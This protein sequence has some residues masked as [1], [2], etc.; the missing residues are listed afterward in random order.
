MAMPKGAA[1]SERRAA[2]TCH[3][4]SRT[5]TQWPGPSWLLKRSNRRCA[6]PSATQPSPST[7]TARATAVA[8][9]ATAWPLAIIFAVFVF[10]S[11]K[12]PA[13]AGAR[14]RRC[15]SARVVTATVNAKPDKTCARPPEKNEQE[16]REELRQR[17]FNRE[18]YTIL[19]GLSFFCVG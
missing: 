4:T 11:A 1:A 15:S 13:T 18:S 14:R 16:E 5:K 10:S 6:N 7:S 17:S 12:A 8:V 2:R 19:L 3:A 9:G